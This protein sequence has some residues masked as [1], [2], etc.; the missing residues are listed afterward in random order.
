MTTL[1]VLLL[2]ILSGGLTV[3]T[4]AKL[5]APWR[6]IV[7]ALCILVVAGASAKFFGTGALTVGLAA[8]ML[9]LAVALN[10]LRYFLRE[11]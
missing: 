11:H 3:M 8:W 10:A 7:A 2:F 6:Y 5:H 4:T 9:A 1:I